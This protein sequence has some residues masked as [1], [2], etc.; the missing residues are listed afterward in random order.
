MN[1]HYFFEAFILAIW[2]YSRKT[3]RVGVYTIRVAKRSLCAKSGGGAGYY[4]ARGQD[5]YAYRVAICCPA[6]DFDG[7]FQGYEKCFWSRM[8]PAGSGEG[9][10]RAAGGDHGAA[11]DLSL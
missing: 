2:G 8:V 10:R 4:C 3:L 1:S 11:T 9:V 6:A 7:F 5:E